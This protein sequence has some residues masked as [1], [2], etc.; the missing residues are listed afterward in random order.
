M[1]AFAPRESYGADE[2]S[3]QD[4]IYTTALRNHIDPNLFLSIARCESGFRIEAK[5]PKSTASGIFQFLNST[6]ITH[7]QAYEL[8][9]E[10]DNPKIQ[11]ELAAKMIANG[12]VGHWNASKSCWNRTY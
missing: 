2:Q 11:I 8:P 12:G 1:I 10:K 6:F 3:I 7:A 4:L 9:L 5:N